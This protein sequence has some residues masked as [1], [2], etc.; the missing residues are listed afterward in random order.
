MNG[1]ETAV[2]LREKPFDRSA[3][4]IFVSASEETQAGSAGRGSTG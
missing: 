1:L 3:P 4:V 2:R